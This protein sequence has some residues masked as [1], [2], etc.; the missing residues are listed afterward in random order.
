MFCTNC[1]KMLRPEA[2]F[3]PSCGNPIS[4]PP[5]KSD[6]ISQDNQP[7]V[8]PAQ[9]APLQDV[10]TAP[11]APDAP[12]IPP[13][14][15]P[16]KH[17]LGF[18]ST[19]KHHAERSLEELEHAI[20][21]RQ[22]QEKE[23]WDN[24]N[25]LADRYRSGQDKLQELETLTGIQSSAVELAKRIAQSQAQ[26]AS[27]QQ[28][29]GL[30]E[31]VIELKKEINK[32]RSEQNE[33]VEALDLQDVGFYQLRYSFIESERYRAE[34]DKIRADQK[35]MVK[36]GTAATCDTQWTV[37]GSIKEGQKM[38][39]A[40]LF[41][42]LRAF[43]GECDACV[44]SVNYRNIAAYEKRLSKL[45]DSLNKLATV[46]HCSVQPAYLELRLSELHLA[47]EYQLKKKTE[48]EEQRAMRE[49]MRE[50]ERARA[51]A[52]KV[53]KDAEKEERHYQ[54]LLQ[55]AQSAMEA[56]GAERRAEMEGRIAELQEQLQQAQDL[57][58]RAIS[59]AQLTKAGHVY[60]I[61]NIGSFGEDV[62]K[63]G[64]TRRLEPIDRVNELG[65]ASVP[66][67]FDI[68]AMIYSTNAPELENILHQEF[69][70]QKLNMVNQ[71][72]EFFRVTIYEI[73]SKV[74]EIAIKHPQMSPNF[75][76][77]YE[78]AA[79]QYA[80]SM[81]A[82]AHMKHEL[83]RSPMK[84]IAAANETLPASVASSENTPVS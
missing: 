73:E 61:S 21:E 56:A 38:V 84:A 26:L 30:Q 70:N 83:E 60:I 79:E 11:R 37:N 66:F 2:Q 80:L 28:E 46:T 55:Q 29:T 57:K 35:T 4:S 54:L 19:K 78:A 49:E 44:A 42:V 10:Q 51:E 3:C 50:E 40:F 20:T 22:T 75:E 27:L 59:Q 64:L 62:Y 13:T 9:D 77:T 18:Q 8:P 33:L 1:G 36:T 6:G 48:Q 58:A 41:I 12:D 68:H 23:M 53:Q 24:L 63:I 52:E 76:I 67:P 32:L 34:L 72:K 17:A 39:K 45:Y 69:A 25:A 5:K 15:K 65:G 31:N 71:R 47:Y 16:Y 74:R 81:A 43:N 14:V 7:P 82:I